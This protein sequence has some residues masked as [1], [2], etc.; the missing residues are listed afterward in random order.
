MRIRR[1]PLSQSG[2]VAH[3]LSS[4]CD[5]RLL[6]PLRRRARA[7]H[8]AQSQRLF[9]FRRCV[10]RQAAAHPRHQGR[11]RRRRRRASRQGDEKGRARRCGVEGGS[12]DPARGAALAWRARQG[13]PLPGGRGFGGSSR[14]C[15]ASRRRPR[16]GAGRRRA[17]RAPRHSDLA[18]VAGIAE[19]PALRF[20]DHHVPAGRRH[21]QDRRSLRAADPEPHP[22][23]RES[24]R[25][26]PGRYRR[27][28]RIRGPCGWRDG[29][30]SEGRLVR[31]HDPAQHSEPDSRS[32]CRR[33]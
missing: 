27:H 1:R 25:H 11:F 30:G 19:F 29:A 6:P 18:P 15:E 23:W 16:R 10:R 24:R 12:G 5:S 2:A 14:L 22:L 7:L 17:D 8:P 33:R 13:L 32:M 31:V 28:D 21:G 3:S 4:L 9:A 26:P 20:S